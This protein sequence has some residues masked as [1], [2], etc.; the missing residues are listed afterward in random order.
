[1]A[2]IKDIG[3]NAL[4]DGVE[5]FTQSFIYRRMQKLTK[6]FLKDFETGSEFDDAMQSF[7]NTLSMRFDFDFHNA[8]YVDRMILHY[9]GQSLLFLFYHLFDLIPSLNLLF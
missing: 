7:I 3:K 4:E 8:F 2:D 5:D 9:P 6:P 1:M